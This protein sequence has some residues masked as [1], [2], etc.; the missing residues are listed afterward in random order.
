[1][2]PMTLQQVGAAVGVPVEEAVRA[3]RVTRV[4]TD[5]RTVEPGDLFVALRG[6]RT[7]G[8][9]FISE[10]AAR[11]AVACVCE[12]A[13]PI[14]VDSRRG[15]QQMVVDDALAALGRLA[16][17]YRERVL[18]VSTIIV[19]VTG[20]NGKTTTKQ[21]IHHALSAALK[22][23]CAPRSF[24]NTLGVALTLLSTDAADKY[25]VVEVGTNHPGEIEALA[26]IVRPHLAV[27][28]SVAE[29]HLE[30][31]GS[32]DGVAAEKAS[33]LRHV[34]RTGLSLVNVDRGEIHRHLARASSRVMTF[35]FSRDARLRVTDVQPGLW[36]TRCT[37]DGRFTVTLPMP[38][39]HHASNA[40]AA[41]GV[42]RWFG[43]APEQIIHRLRTFEPLG[44]RT[45]VRQAGE[46]TI[47]DD[48]Y[49]ANPG[50][51]TAAIETLRAVRGRGRVLVAGDMLELGPA[52]DEL[53]TRVVQAALAA[54][55]EK[56]VAVGPLMGRA[57]EVL[58]AE[59]NGTHIVTCADAAEA[60][61]AV[62]EAV[63]AD[64]VVWVK[65]SRRM[66]LE[67]V[68]RHLETRFGRAAVA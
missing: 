62:E 13:N 40:A 44:G 5:S 7:D 51:M 47:V 36:E 64:D 34:A 60:C 25:L 65:G 2:I 42:A 67:R 19:A 61:A 14:T 56:L 50:S 54:G 63:A 23:K 30:G 17:Y 43:L 52:A 53:H 8:H 4:V 58:R 35:G 66:E 3:T 21:M 24:N 59:K 18:P 68:V 33:L 9:Q 39:P 6:E 37:L 28:T 16:A 57:V 15:V 32:V 45:S 49:N 12:R 38:G 31:L 55:V 48:S 26:A 22:G 27:I 1:M 46:L 29:S 11:G 10:A 41:F 20:S